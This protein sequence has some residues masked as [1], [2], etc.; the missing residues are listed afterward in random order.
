MSRSVFYTWRKRYGKVNEHNAKIPRDNWLTEAE[1]KAIIDYH[2]LH[3][4]D[5]YRRLTYM[6]IDEGVAAAS[7]A[8]VYR[9]LSSAGLLK[10]WNRRS[11][12]GK[13]FA[14]PDAPHLH[15]HVD[16]SYINIKGT[17]YYLCSVLDGYSRSI[18]H[19]EIRER[20][21]ERDV[22][23]I[24]Q[25]CRERYPGTTPRIITDNGPQFVAKDFKEFIKIAG[26]THVKTSPYYPQSNGKI[27]RFHKTLKQ[28]CIRE[29]IPLT[30][31][32]ARRVVA[33]FVEHYNTRRL[34]SAVGY[35]TPK[36][37][38]EG[39]KQEIL[40]AREEKLATARAQ[41]AKVRAAEREIMNA[42]IH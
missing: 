10:R 33:E 7:P 40:A 21:E 32:D 13:G 18:L 24:I 9:V 23:T 39:R 42:S 36:D 3:P 20:M 6:M 34:H 28:D 14:Q 29:K 17:F 41:R 26:M 12:K 4:L 15:W 22:E 37:V 2:D 16:V 27:E 8:S 25:R 35:V 1:K 5:G 31:E 38:L 19:F 30:L 11:S